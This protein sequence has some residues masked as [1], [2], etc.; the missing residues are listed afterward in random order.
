M[1]RGGT[2]TLPT[3]W[4]KPTQRG[5]RIEIPTRF[6]SFVRALLAAWLVFWA[7]GMAV[8]A[9]GWLGVI[10]APIPPAPIWI[11]FVLAFTAAGVFVAWHL[12]WVLWGREVVELKEGVLSISRRIGPW[13]GRPRRWAWEG[14]RDLRVGSFERKV[15]YPSWGREF[16]GREDAYLTF[17][18]EGR[19]HP[20]GRGL[21]RAEAEEV[22]ELLRGQPTGGSA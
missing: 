4:V 22:L 10:A 13:K 6:D 5:L 2:E 16:V 20:F 12:A 18:F 17:N 21:S 8:I 19:A 7:A 14:V 15:V 1:R 3:P 9:L 11:A